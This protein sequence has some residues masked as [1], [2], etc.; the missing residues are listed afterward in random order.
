MLVHFKYKC[1]KRDE[2][3]HTKDGYVAVASYFLRF[4]VAFF[5]HCVAFS[6]LVCRGPRMCFVHSIRWIEASVFGLVQVECLKIVRYW[7]AT[8]TFAPHYVHYPEHVKKTHVAH[9][10][11]LTFGRTKMAWIWCSSAN[12]E[13]LLVVCNKLC[14]H[15]DA[16]GWYGEWRKGAHC[17]HYPARCCQFKLFRILIKWHAATLFDF[18]ERD[19]LID[20][21]VMSRRISWTEHIEVVIW[22]LGGWLI[23]ATYC[24][25]VLL[26]VIV[27]NEMRASRWQNVMPNLS[28]N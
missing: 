19:E 7:N 20:A 26:C 18:F 12:L 3:Y 28:N 22:M 23:D 17:V 5:F 11:E 21:S 13:Q 24:D 4:F 8:I 16:T 6:H 15:L 9:C 10:M 27:P 25:P 14:A 1:W 2:Q